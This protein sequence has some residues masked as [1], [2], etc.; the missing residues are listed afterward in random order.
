M[1]MQRTVQTSV[2]DGIAVLRV[3]NPPINALGPDLRRALVEEMQ[4]AAA[5]PAVRGVVVTGTGRVFIAG[6]DIKK[7]HEP[8]VGP[9]VHDLLTLIDGMHKPVVA[10][11]QGLALG[12]GYEIAMA[13]HAR[14]AAPGIRVGLPETSLGLIPGAG[15]TQRLPRLVGPGRALDLIV[16]GRHVR[17]DEALA[18]GMID[19]IAEDDPVAAA[20]RWIDTPGAALSRT[21]DRTPWQDNAAAERDAFEARAK[22]LSALGTPAAAAAIE[23][24][25]NVFKQDFD[26]GLARETEAFHRLRESPEARALIHAF[27]AERDCA[28]VRGIDRDTPR[29]PIRKVAILG[30]GTMGCG[31]GIS[32]ANAGYDVTMIDAEAA[33]LDAAR[34]RVRGLYDDRVA[35]RRV[36]A[37]EAE[38]AFARFDWVVGL[39]EGVRDA[40]LVVEA[41]FEDMELKKRVFAQLDAAAPA[42]AILASNTS[43]QNIN[44]MAAVT[45]RPEKVLGMHYF[46]PAHVM[47]LLEVVR[48]AK[49]APDTLATVLDIARRTGKTP[50]VAG[51]CYGFV[52]NRMLWLRTVQTQQLLLEGASPRDIDSVLVEFGFR[53][54]PCQMGDMAGL[55]VAWRLRKARGERQEPVDTLA[56]AGRWGQKT[57]KG[58]YLYPEGARAGV[59]DPEVTELIAGVA[60]KLG[61]A[62]REVNREE[63]R[64]RLLLPLINE[65]TRVLEEGIV[66]RASDIDVVYLHGYGWP[67]DKGGPMFHADQ[68]G[69]PRLVADLD[70]MAEALG[71]EAL[72][73]SALLR[74]LAREGG[75][76]LASD[77]HAM[78]EVPA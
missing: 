50:V 48:G 39:E 47:R 78:T 67:R 53:M 28:H 27:I 63:I 68:Y 9:Q 40:D 64:K 69:L 6:A 54:G 45:R 62:R 25:R 4:K 57:G 33:P 17:A 10:A 52:G 56:D 13:C 16:S 51:V 8:R 7:I 73:P 77:P 12:G 65:G 5:D 74:R 46:S 1:A 29:L 21:R 60:R 20:R 44:E 42:R 35:R 3:D 24:V 31:I 2:T 66:E 49:T 70:A 36:P 37:A 19:E 41:V 34:A 11:L 55:D 23:A 26:A 18:L 38:T 75:S 30:C 71:D 61:V 22:A 32:M 59:D 14:I 76:L 43:Y 15:G 58:Y 72:R